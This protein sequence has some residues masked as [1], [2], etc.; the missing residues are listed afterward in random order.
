MSDRAAVVLLALAACLA[1]CG[2]STPFSAPDQTGESPFAEL[3]PTRLTYDAGADIHPHW[4]SD[5]RALLYS[6]ERQLPGAE[7]PDRCLGALPPDGGQRLGEWCWPG[8]E[9]AT[10]R[11]GIEAGALDDTG[12][13]FFVHHYGAGTK[14]PNP[15]RGSAYLASDGTLTSSPIRLFDLLVPQAGASG[16]WDYFLAPVFTGPDHVT[17]LGT[18][19]TIEQPCPDCAWDTV[20]TGL[21]LVRVSLTTPAEM[22]LL[23][24]VAGAGFL[25]WDR[26]SDRFFFARDGRIETVPTGGGEPMM[27][28]QLPRSTDRSDPAIT[29]LAAAAGRLVV[30]YHWVEG[31]DRRNLLGVLLPS[32]EIATIA[33]SVTFPRWGELALSPDGRRLVVERRDADG[34]RD[35]YL[36][37]LP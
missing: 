36:Y 32:G 10:R 13:L 30:S 12:R 11:D 1:G 20:Y 28:W 7:Y 4:T 27:V 34:A 19:V 5:G 6:F 8:V 15:F 33:S 9:E 26:E 24:R 2:H 22:T 37:E 31:G 14:Q 18:A 21:D 3:V 25:S 23:A 17:G 35:L 16:R 29:G